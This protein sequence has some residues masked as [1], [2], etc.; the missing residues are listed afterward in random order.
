MSTAATARF[1]RIPPKHI[2][3]CVYYIR[4]YPGLHPKAQTFFKKSAFLADSKIPPPFPEGK[5]AG[6]RT[7]EG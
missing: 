7:K 5:A 3:S 2:I 1:N 4:N 6:S